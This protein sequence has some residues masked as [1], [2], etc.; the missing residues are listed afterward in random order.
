[1]IYGKQ[2]NKTTLR[3]LNTAWEENKKLNKV[4]VIM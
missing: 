1:M 3:V 2:V 4:N